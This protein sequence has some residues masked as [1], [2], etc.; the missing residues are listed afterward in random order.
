MYARITT[1]GILAA[2]AVTAAW[3][4]PQ[5]FTLHSTGAVDLRATGKEARFG[6]VPDAIRGRPILMVSLGATAASGALQLTTLADRPLGPGRYPIRSSWSELP[7]DAV[8]FHAAFIPGSVEQ[9]LGWYH[10][11]T[12]TV[13]I[14]EVGP[15]RLGGTFEVEARGFSAADPLDEERWVTVR[16]SFAAVGDSTFARIAAVR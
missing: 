8:A 3:G 11:E 12:G 2:V 16:G 13:T 15:D 10:G 14:T 1:L 5:S 6:T 7:A 4:S 9:P